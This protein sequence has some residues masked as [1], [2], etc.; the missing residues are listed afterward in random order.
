MLYGKMNSTGGQGSGASKPFV[1][2]GN[3]DWAHDISQGNSFV[4]FLGD[5]ERLGR[6][7][8]RTMLPTRLEAGAEPSQRNSRRAEASQADFRPSLIESPF[9]LVSLWR[10]IQERRR[11]PKIT[12]PEE[13]YRGE[14]SL[15]VSDM[16]PLYNDL[17]EQIR[18]LF[19]KP[20][21][22]AIPIT[23]QPAE[24][25]DIWQDYKQQPASFGNSLLFHAI[26]LAALLLPYIILGI[27]K[28]PAP[29]AEVIPLQLS[30]YL[31]HIPP[32]LKQA[33]GGG[34]GGDRTPKP[35]SKGA[36]PK[37]TWRQL[38]PPVTKITIPKPQL[39]VEPTLL[40]PPDLKIKMA[41]NM[42]GNPT[43]VPAPPSNGPGAGGGIGTGAGTGVGS[44]KGGGLGPGSGG[45]TG[46]G[47]FSVG[48]GVSQ[49]IPIYDPDPPYSEQARKAKYQGTV[50]V[51][52]VVDGQGLVHDV[53]VVKPLGLGLDEEAVNTIQ[54]WK[55]KPAER[56][57][58][59]VPVRIMVEVTFRLF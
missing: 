18:S 43:A 38:A 19:E 59:P 56:N 54:G 27:H 25:G 58:V 48:G 6:G 33:G 50:V 42:W 1:W 40:G 31:L 4:N 8:L 35:P 29:Q 11:E 3:F 55:F 28:Q 36:A 57:G 5:A 41:D 52:I 12:V 23:S 10:L 44:G 2:W 45:G 16:A 17:R 9:I 37:F 53:R 51:S 20:Q 49:P 39:P 34:G 26:L 13:Y 14:G 47:V 15:P 46:G 21:P 22:A 7:S 30:P 32:G 24:V